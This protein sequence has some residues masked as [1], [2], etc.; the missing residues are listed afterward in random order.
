MDVEITLRVDGEAH[1]LSVDTRTTLLDAL[2]APALYRCLRSPPSVCR[3]F[4][5]PVGG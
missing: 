5:G 1:R 2:R 3:S 4:R